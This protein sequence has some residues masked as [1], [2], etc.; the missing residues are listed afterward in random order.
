MTSHGFLEV[1]SPQEKST[2]VLL[3]PIP[4][5]EFR[6]LWRVV[7]NSNLSSPHRTR[8]FPC[9]H[10]GP[11]FLWFLFHSHL[12]V[13]KLQFPLLYFLLSLRGIFIVIANPYME[14]EWESQANKN[15]DCET[16]EI[17]RSSDSHAWTVVIDFLSFVETR[18]SYFLLVLQV[19]SWEDK[20]SN[21][22]PLI[23][24]IGRFSL[25]S[26]KVEWELGKRSEWLSWLP[27]WSRPPSPLVWVT[28]GAFCFCPCP[29]ESILIT[30]ARVLLLN[31][32]QVMSIHC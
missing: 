10:Y 19:Y 1:V 24:C 28:P 7:I 8:V 2:E 14:M 29:S 12:A 5:G 4:Q 32:S 23:R 26:A 16:Q 30:G 6:D 31:L 13:R 17:Q 11:S 18:G 21:C 20:F 9:C 25:A 15:G 3:F 27:P 22:P